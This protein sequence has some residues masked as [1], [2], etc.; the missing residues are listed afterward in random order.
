M[1]KNEQK[2]NDLKELLADEER[3]G[4]LGLMQHFD[5]LINVL[6]EL[7]WTVKRER[8]YRERTGGELHEKGD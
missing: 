1:T 6:P 5:L 4:Q 7:S 3:S 2:L 8:D